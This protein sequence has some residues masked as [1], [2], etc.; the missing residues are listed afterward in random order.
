MARPGGGTAS[1]VT[2]GWLGRGLLLGAVLVA[3]TVAAA[4]GGGSAQSVGPTLVASGQIPRSDLPAP[5]SEAAATL[6][7]TQNTVPLAKQDP[8]TALFTAIGAFQSCLSGM[9]VTYIG[10]P[11]AQDPNSPADD[12]TYIKALE[13]CAT[14]SNILQALKAAQTAQSS[15]TPPQVKVQNKL[16]L[17]WR[18]C[19]IGRGWKIPQP[20]PNAKGLLFSFTSSGA[21]Q[22]QP[23]PGQSLLS[24]SDLQA[25]AA[26]A[27]AEGP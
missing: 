11:S 17:K 24:S 12:P 10:V 15:L 5:G 23:P 9:G 13:T 7:S 22:Y 8:T 25:C 1:R 20:A 2:T 4:C 19:M 16:Y 14:K 21:A 27:E 18:I 6:S 26:K 3:G